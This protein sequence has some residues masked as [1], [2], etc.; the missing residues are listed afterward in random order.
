MNFKSMNIQDI[1]AWCKENNQVEWLKAEAAKQMPCKVYPKVEKDGKMV[2][3]KSQQPTIEMR[4]ITFIQIKMDFVNTFMPS[5]A[6]QKKE[7][8][9]TFYELIKN[10]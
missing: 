1:I 2:A 6:P 3:D 8:K 9:P 7:A 10:L 4:P 5:I